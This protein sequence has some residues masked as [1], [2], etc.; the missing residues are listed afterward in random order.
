MTKLDKL[1]LNGNNITMVCKTIFSCH[2]LCMCLCTCVHVC[3]CVC[4][5]ACMCVR[6]SGCGCGKCVL[7]GTIIYILLVD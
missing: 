2:D 3:V 4:V 1:L 7:E 5:R 6:L